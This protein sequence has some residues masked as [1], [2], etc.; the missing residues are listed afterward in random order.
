MSQE[1]SAALGKREACRREREAR[2]EA[3]SHA[4]SILPGAALRPTL[5][6]V[7][8]LQGLGQVSAPQQ[9]PLW[10]SVQ[11]LPKPAPHAAAGVVAETQPSPA[12]TP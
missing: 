5:P 3:G 4:L 8:P 1:A 9:P 2:A 10:A 12:V 11:A 6:S 7:C